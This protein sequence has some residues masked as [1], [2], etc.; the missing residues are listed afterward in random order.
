MKSVLE[1]PS[2]LHKK[3]IMRTNVSSSLT[4]FMKIII[5][6]F[7]GV[8]FGTLTLAFLLADHVAVSFMSM[9]N[10]RIFML[11][12]FL[13]GMLFLYWA[14]MRLKRVEMDEHF[15][16][17][18]NYFKHY[19]YPFHNVEKIVESDYLMFRSMHVHF[20]EAGYFGEKVSFVAHRH[21]FNDFMNDNPAIFKQFLDTDTEDTV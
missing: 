9:R 18:S 10:F 1:S 17:V 21:R 3:W 11:A 15:I 6:V 8:F 13:L 16:Y 4:L 12:F 7:W 14:V 2:E 19:K 5:P 20:K